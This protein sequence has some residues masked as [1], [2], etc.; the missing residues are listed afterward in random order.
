MRI[1]ADIADGINSKVSL[2]FPSRRYEAFLQW[3]NNAS[4]IV[5]ELKRDLGRVLRKRQLQKRLQQ[6]Q[7]PD[8]SKY[9][10]NL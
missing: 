2:D 8:L 10:E 6:Q 5:A 1:L 9:P 4:V 7:Q 3:N